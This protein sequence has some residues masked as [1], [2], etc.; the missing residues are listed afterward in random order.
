MSNH[1]V[2]Q[3]QNLPFPT[4]PRV[5]ANIY[6]Q[7]LV[8]NYQSLVAC[9]PTATPIGVVKADAYGHGISFVVPA[10]LS[11]GCRCFAVATPEEAMSLRE[12]LCEHMPF[13]DTQVLVLGYTHPEDVVAMAHHHITVT[14]L[15]LAHA[16]AMAKTALRE[17]VVVKCHVALDTGMN[18][19]GLEA[20]DDDAC[21]QAAHDVMKI[22]EMDGLC[23]TGMF[24]HFSTADDDLD[25]VSATDSYTH[26][27]LARY[28]LVYDTLCQA[29]KRPQFCHVCNSV[30]SIRWS[31]VT[32]LPQLDGV[33]FGISLYGYGETTPKNLS[34]K[35]VMQLVTKVVHLHTCPAHGKVGYGGEY[36]PETPRTIAT[37][38]VG[39]ADGFDRGFK[40]GL[41]WVHTSQGNFKVPLVGRICMDQCMIDVTGLPITMGDEVILFGQEREALESL[42]RLAGTIPYE[43]LCLIS[44]RVPRFLV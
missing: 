18:R 38:P 26:T 43:P 33:R 10:L 6:T 44:G 21:L 32:N 41:V 13:E 42:C 19:I 40:G 37:L 2:Y 16:K 35:P 9:N 28:M 34:L 27:Q 5:W 25:S 3:H 31:S 15:S 12:L 14:C 4:H 17:G 24:T 7:N 20:Q 8:H 1:P 23:V 11:A 22:M 39:Y 30:T 36:E 29:G